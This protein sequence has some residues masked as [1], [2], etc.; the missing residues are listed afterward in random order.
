MPNEIGREGLRASFVSGSWV[1][2][3]VS[4]SRCG[5]LLACTAFGPGQGLAM[6]LFDVGGGTVIDADDVMKTLI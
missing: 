4:V 3:V 6:W 2:R 1:W 5:P